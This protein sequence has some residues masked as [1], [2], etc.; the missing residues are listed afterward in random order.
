M[1]IG[2]RLQ[3][4]GIACTP[5]LLVQV[6]NGERTVDEAAEEL[7]RQCRCRPRPLA[8]TLPMNRTQC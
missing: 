4:A 5:L 7:M 6:A 2:Q 3:Q 1:L 8:S